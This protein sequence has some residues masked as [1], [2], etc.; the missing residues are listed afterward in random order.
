MKGI[1]LNNDFELLVNVRR[2]QNGLIAGG[3]VVGNNE[4][5]CAAIVLQ[6][7]PGELKEDPLLG[8]GLTKFVRGKVSSSAIDQ[9]IRQHLTRAGINYNQY[10]QRIV[11]TSNTDEL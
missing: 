2:L 5:Q 9:R 10:K 6:M 3:L 11:L 4:D 7:Q 1:L 8:A